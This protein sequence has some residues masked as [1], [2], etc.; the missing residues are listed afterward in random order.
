M[1]KRPVVI[2]IAGG[3]CS[4][5]TSVTRAVYEVFKE[6][7][8][9]VIEQDYYYK[10]QA[11]L[12]FDERLLTNDDHPFA[13]D[14]DLLIEHVTSLIDRKPVQKPVY[15]YVNHTRAEEVDEDTFFHSTES[16]GTVVSSA[17]ELMKK[18]MDER[19][20]PTEWNIYGA[21]ASDGDN[22]TDD[23]PKCRKLLADDILPK[24]RY[25]AYIQVAPEEQNLWLE[26][27]QL[28]LDG[29]NLLLRRRLR[30]AHPQERHCLC[31]VVEGCCE[32]FK[33][34]RLIRVDVV[35][36]VRFR[37]RKVCCGLWA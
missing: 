5:K 11:H 25:F 23:F 8:V 1:T 30:A 10:D 32:G 13:F 20:S 7:S 9:V 24:V 33:L 26:Y 12:T 37:C 36:W 14:T 6:H 3:S 27:A 15:D 18:I 28:A 22:W 29:G 2:G 21:Q 16:G 17:L 35:R 19:Y 4:G 34:S 31:C